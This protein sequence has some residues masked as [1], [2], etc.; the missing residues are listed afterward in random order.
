MTAKKPPE[1]R[2]RVVL[3]IDEPIATKI[4]AEAIYQRITLS[5]MTERLYADAIARCVAERAIKG[6]KKAKP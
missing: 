2:S 3:M 4:R 6:G 1:T 5:M